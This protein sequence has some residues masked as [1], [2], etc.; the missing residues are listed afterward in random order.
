MADPGIVRNRLK[1]EATISNARAFLAVQ[2][3]FGSFDGYIWK[4]VFSF[5]RWQD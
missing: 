2:K 1:I 5:C 3:E 4:F